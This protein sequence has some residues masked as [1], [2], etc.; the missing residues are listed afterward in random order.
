MSSV[1]EQN[2]FNYEIK[3]GIGAHFRAVRR[4]CLRGGPAC[5]GPRG[6]WARGPRKV[7]ASQLP[8]NLRD[9]ERRWAQARVQAGVCVWHWEEGGASI[10]QL[11]FLCKTGSKVFG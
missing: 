11:L 1:I 3:S 5:D 7:E 9:P 8:L 4:T 6:R 2:C 10:Q